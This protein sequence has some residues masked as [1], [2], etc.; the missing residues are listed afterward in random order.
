MA[1]PILMQAFS[2]PLRDYGEVTNHPLISEDPGCSKILASLGQVREAR[3]TSA[4]HMQC[5][6]RSAEQTILRSL[7]QIF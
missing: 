4:S 1:G 7:R 5:E 3:T 2:P 6:F